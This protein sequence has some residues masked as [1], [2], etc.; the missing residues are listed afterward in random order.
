MQASF[1]IQ[2]SN[3]IPFWE[4]PQTF[5]C[6]IYKHS[7]SR[8]YSTGFLL[9]PGSHLSLPYVRIMDAIIHFLLA[10]SFH[11]R[12]IPLPC[13]TVLCLVDVMTIAAAILMTARDQLNA[14]AA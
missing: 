9:F 11:I 3:Y 8:L 4:I 1:F 14:K 6:I 13:Q 2:Y 7:A 5:V 12:P 10:S